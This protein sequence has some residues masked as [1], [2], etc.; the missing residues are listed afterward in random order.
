MK[1]DKRDVIDKKWEGRREKTVKRSESKMKT[2]K[3]TEKKKKGRD[4]SQI[5]LPRNQKKIYHPFH[6]NTNIKTNPKNNHTKKTHE[7]YTPKNPTTVH[8]LNK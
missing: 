7:K 3:G 8:K 4:I 1:E 6:F 2:R 5:I